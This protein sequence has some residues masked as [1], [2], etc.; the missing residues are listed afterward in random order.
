VSRWPGTAVA[1]RAD[2]LGECRHVVATQSVI[3]PA[4]SRYPALH[5]PDCSPSR[6]VGSRTVGNASRA[7]KL[8]ALLAA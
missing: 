1:A 7:Q 6:S 3:S 8:P 4:V 2:G 5:S